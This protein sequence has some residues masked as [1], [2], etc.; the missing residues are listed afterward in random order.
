MLHQEINKLKAQIDSFNHLLLQY[1]KKY[2]LDSIHFEKQY[3]S[4]SLGDD[5][6]FI[7][8][9]STIEMKRKAKE[10]IVNLQG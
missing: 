9:I 3:E 6:D 4:G 10:Y 5:I 1:E 2:N 7:E 8:W